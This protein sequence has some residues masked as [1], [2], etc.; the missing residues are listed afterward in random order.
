[1]GGVEYHVKI[2]DKLVCNSTAE[3]IQLPVNPHKNTIGGP[4]LVDVGRMTTCEGPFPINRG[5]RIDTEAFYDYDLHPMFV[6]SYH[7]QSTM[8]ILTSEQIGC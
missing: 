1:M 4:A 6:D 5:D 8:T 7:S 2:N 3:Y